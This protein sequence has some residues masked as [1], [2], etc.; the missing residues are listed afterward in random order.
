MDELDLK[1]ALLLSE[2][3]RITYRDVAKQLNIT[4]PTARYRVKQLLDSGKVRIHASL[5]LK[6]FPELLIAYVGIK[7][8]GNPIECLDLLSKIPEVV[9]TVNTTG[10]YDII[11]LIAANSRE[12]LGNILIN[13][14]INGKHHHATTI[15]STETHIVLFEKKMM[16]PADKII[17][18]LDSQK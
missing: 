5:D 4:E 18:T 1:I 12:R 2:D 13:N 3:G 9:Y 7:Q 6:Q 10:R 14:L 8:I 15:T 17:N 16:I 11:A